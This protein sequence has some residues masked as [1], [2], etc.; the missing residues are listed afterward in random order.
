MSHSNIKSTQQLGL[1]ESRD[2][3][4]CGCEIWPAEKSLEVQYWSVVPTNPQEKTYCS[5][6]LEKSFPLLKKQTLIFSLIPTWK[7]AIYLTHLAP[8]TQNGGILWSPSSGRLTWHFWV[9]PKHLLQTMPDLSFLLFSV[10]VKSDEVRKPDCTH[11]RLTYP[12]NLQNLHV[13]LF[14]KSPS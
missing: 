4:A 10:L 13:Q 5:N 3:G 6:M 9:F 11:V 12:Y 14:T 7:A 2:N 1:E 8:Q